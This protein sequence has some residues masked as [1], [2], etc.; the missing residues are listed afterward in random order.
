[1]LTEI[2]LAL[3]VLCF[4]M[5]SCYFNTLKHESYNINFVRCFR[6]RFY[7]SEYESFFCYVNCPT[8]SN[9]ISS[10]AFR[11]I[12]LYFTE[13]YLM[14]EKVLKRSPKKSKNKTPMKN[15]KIPKEMIDNLSNSQRLWFMEGS[16]LEA[17][18]LNFSI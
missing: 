10:R 8:L 15:E 6:I 1:M 17:F 12:K 11:I 4:F 9:I 13:C 16:L 3:Q 18:L 7:D 2:S 5:E 14:I